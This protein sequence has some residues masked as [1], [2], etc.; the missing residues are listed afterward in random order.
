MERVLHEIKELKR[1]GVI[2]EY[3]IGGAVAAAFYMEPVETADLDVFVALPESASSVVT[4]APIYNFLA[5]RGHTPIG[6]HVLIHGIPVQF[7][8]ADALTQEALEQAVERTMG[9]EAAR[10]M[11]P[12]HLAAIMLRLNRP[13][14]RMRIE[15]LLREAELDSA[16]LESILRRHGLEERWTALM[17][18][19]HG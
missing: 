5:N 15:M 11:R 14:D 9:K 1:Q 2:V 6:E 12:E 19:L 3:A 13:K 16:T 7:L 18:L 8:G 17:R 4:L 10:V